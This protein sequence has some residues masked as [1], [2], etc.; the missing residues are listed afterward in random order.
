MRIF[1]T[2]SISRDSILFFHQK[3]T[4]IGDL[5]INDVEDF[6]GGA[7]ANVAFSLVNNC[8]ANPIF[9]SCVGNDHL[10]NELLNNFKKNNVDISNIKLCDGYK[11][12]RHIIFYKDS[13]EVE[14]FVY[15]GAIDNFSLDKQI[16]DTINQE[17]IFYLAPIKPSTAKII[18]DA[19]S[20]YSFNL[21]FNPG[22][23]LFNN[24]EL[25]ID[26]LKI[27]YCLFFNE[28]EILAY[29]NKGNIFSAAKYFLDRGVAIVNVTA[30]KFGAFSFIS[31]SCYYSP[32]YK[33]SV[34]NS[35]GCGDIFSSGFIGAL[36]L[37]DNFTTAV[38]YGNILSSIAATHLSIRDFQITKNDINNFID[39]FYD[40][41]MFDN[42]QNNFF[43]LSVVNYTSK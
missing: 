1:I 21:F 32:G 25:L 40:R 42:S 29:S 30:G 15:S 20:C 34:R 3:D 41:N 17:D 18:F 26:N 12:T 8:N 22:A 33:V 23:A 7:G 5:F 43:D 28:N 2:G 31:N 36:F 13:G 14:T 19:L 37:E 11:S 16:L 38:T 9:L 27:I 35:I 24:K 4:E 6:Y 10:G 39:N